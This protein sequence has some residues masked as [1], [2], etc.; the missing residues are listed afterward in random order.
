[1]TRPAAAEYNWARNQ[2]YSAARIHHPET[3]AEVQRLVRAG[4]TVRALGSRHSFNRVA[5]STGDLISLSRLDRV[6]ALDRARRTV[7]IE[8]GVRYGE[9]G[10]Y[11][12]G[13]GFALENLAS[14][15]HISVAGAVSTATHGSGERNRNLAAAVSAMQIVGAGGE[16]ITVARDTHGDRFRG[17]VVALGALGIVTSLTLDVVPTFDVR[18]EVYERLPFEE[19]CRHFDAIQA[20]AYSVSLFTSW[21]SDVVEQLWLKR[22][23]TSRE[24]ASVPL[25]D[26]FFGA[27]RAG[28][29]LHPLP[30]ISAESCTPQMGRAG[31][32]HDRLP[33]FRLEHTPSNGDELQSEYFVPRAHA[34]AALRALMRIGPL[35]ASRLLVSEIRTV[36][37]DALWLSPCYDRDSVA[38]HFTWRPDWLAV[39]TILPTIEEALA[40]FGARPHWGKLF[41]MDAATLRSRYERM[42]DFRELLAEYDA[43]GTFR[44]AFVD[45]YVVR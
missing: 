27:T 29:D 37:A 15:P 41:S 1:V 16:L 8:G 12:H 19:L 3:V 35:I 20:A 11:L 23:V 26:T 25:P 38:F 45:E 44:N 18:Q 40:P 30:G 4:T 32:W 17:M 42:N 24:P 36:A 43:A 7:T 39:R 6:T 9:L 5:D 10:A 34:V 14:L 33:H 13:Q 22:V 31:A 2:S 21:R 28:E